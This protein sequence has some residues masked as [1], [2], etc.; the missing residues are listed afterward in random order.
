MVRTSGFQSESPSSTLGGVIWTFSSAVEQAPVKCLAGGSNPS[1]SYKMR[2][3][4]V[5]VQEV[6]KHYTVKDWL[7]SILNA[8]ET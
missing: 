8:A 2:I 5:S 6:V 4:M 3:K 1:M 7:V